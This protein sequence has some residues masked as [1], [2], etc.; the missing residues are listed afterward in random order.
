[1][2]CLTLRPLLN[3]WSAREERSGADGRTFVVG[4][5]SNRAWRE[6]IGSISTEQGRDHEY[7]EA[8]KVLNIRTL[9]AH[10][11]SNLDQAV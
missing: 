2:G 8:K 3:D 4:L 6:L 10:T 11:I 7:A 1:V 5:W 9:A